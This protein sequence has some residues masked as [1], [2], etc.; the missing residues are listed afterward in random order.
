[1][2]PTNRPTDAPTRLASWLGIGTGQLAVPAIQPRPDPAAPTFIDQV[3]EFAGRYG[4]DPG[5]LADALT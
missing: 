4:A 1:M 5:R 2:F 3:R